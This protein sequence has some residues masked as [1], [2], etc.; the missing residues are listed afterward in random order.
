MGFIIGFLAFLFICHLYGAIVE[1]N[2]EEKVR[3]EYIERR[4]KELNL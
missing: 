4:K 3:R 2:A 1:A